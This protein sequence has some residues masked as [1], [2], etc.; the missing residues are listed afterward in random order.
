M[1]PKRKELIFLSVLV[2]T[3]VLLW[4]IVSVFLLYPVFSELSWPLVSL[5]AVAFVFIVAWALVIV[6]V[7]S[8][9][10]LI[11][12]WAFASYAGV[13]W[14][15]DPVFLAAAS[16]LF[17]GGIVGYFRAKRA[18]QITFEG[19][20]TRPLRKS[21]PLTVTCLTIA[22]SASYYL[23]TTAVPVDVVSMLPES[24]FEKTIAYSAPAIK[25]V[26]PSFNVSGTVGD[27]ALNQIRKESVKLTREQETLVVDEVIGQMQRELGFAIRASDPYTRLLYRTGVSTMERRA[28][29]YKKYFPVVYALGLFLTIRFLAWPLYM[30]AIGA[31]V[32]ILR[33][34][35][36]FGI[37]E[38]RVIPASIVAYSLS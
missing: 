10:V 20:L 28:G 16:L 32:L 1:S 8:T 26:F 31:C 22:F 18:M 12:A 36:R 23:V 24:F 21:L 9:A 2:A 37:I 13:L 34:L 38:M 30:L 25:K 15:R 4:Y 33:G 6:L 11:L 5:V 19:S 29:D 35:H 17:V 27:F 7:E 14:F 3:A